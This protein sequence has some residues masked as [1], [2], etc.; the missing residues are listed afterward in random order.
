MLMALSVRN[1]SK[2]LTSEVP[3]IYYYFVRID[4]QGSTLNLGL[5]PIQMNETIISTMLRFRVFNG[6]EPK[7][8]VL[9]A[10]EQSSFVPTQVHRTADLRPTKWETFPIN[11]TAVH[12][13]P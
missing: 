3:A 4:Y 7:S 10:S 8:Q 2:G 12:L 6:S 5:A 9:I 11:T 13:K 1:L